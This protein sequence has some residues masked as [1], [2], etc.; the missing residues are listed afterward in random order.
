MNLDLTYSFG[1]TV[2]HPL[3]QR[4]LHYPF[5]DTV[6]VQA[7]LVGRAS[8]LIE[9]V[10]HVQ[11]AALKVLDAAEDTMDVLGVALD[12][13][14]ACQQ[15]VCLQLLHPTPTPH[16]CQA[17]ARMQAIFQ[18]LPIIVLIFGQDT[19]TQVTKALQASNQRLVVL[20]TMAKSSADA[21]QTYDVEAEDKGVYV[22][23]FDH[24]DHDDHDEDEDWL[25]SLSD[26]SAS[27]SAFAKA[28]EDAIS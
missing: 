22:D 19:Q 15:F 16:S 18:R 21:A 8:A 5:V 28:M 2:E 10:W 4:T 23:V 27:A 6:P 3:V 26:T 17:F 14:I 7:Q 12:T 24:D 20:Q 1:G 25:V 9:D 13:I 11:D